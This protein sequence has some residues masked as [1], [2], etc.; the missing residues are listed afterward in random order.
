MNLPQKKQCEINPSFYQFINDEV[1]PLTTLNS[2]S[3]WFDFDC[4]INDF[5]FKIRNC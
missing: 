1:L 2:D 5:S 3:F 4:L